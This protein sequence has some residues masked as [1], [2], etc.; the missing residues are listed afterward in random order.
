MTALLGPCDLLLDCSVSTLGS[1]S[2]IVKRIGSS[3]RLQ[4]R[5]SKC[6]QVRVLE[7]TWE[8]DARFLPAGDPLLLRNEAG[9]AEAAQ[10][11]LLEVVIEIAVVLVLV[12]T[13]HVCAGFL[14][15]LAQLATGFLAHLPRDRRG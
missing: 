14:E 8:L 15:A 13:E 5:G 2:E 10:Q 3:G 1:S 11:Q 9:A 7:A 4:G 6:Q 12:K